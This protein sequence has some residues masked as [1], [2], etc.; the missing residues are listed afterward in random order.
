MLGRCTTP[1]HSPNKQFQLVLERDGCFARSPNVLERIE[2][3]RWVLVQEP[4][5]PLPHRKAP[6]RCGAT[7]VAMPKSAKPLPK[8]LRRKNSEPSW[9]KWFASGASLLKS[10]SKWSATPEPIITQSPSAGRYPAGCKSEKLTSRSLAKSPSGDRRYRV[11][12]S[13]M[14]PKSMWCCI[15]Q[16]NRLSPRRSAVKSIDIS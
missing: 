15:W 8:M 6:V 5:R 1:L 14:K 9:G 13:A 7:S 10:T 4:N 16:W 11:S 3:F 12:N 2:R